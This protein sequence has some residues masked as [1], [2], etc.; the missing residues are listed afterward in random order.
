MYED[1]EGVRLDKKKAIELFGKACDMKNELGCK[2]YALLK[3][4]GF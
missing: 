3:G 4:Q 2:N 1:G